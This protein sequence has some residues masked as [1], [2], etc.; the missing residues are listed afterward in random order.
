[1]S[2]L[3]LL[4]FLDVCKWIFL[5]ILFLVIDTCCVKGWEVAHWMF[6]RKED[7]FIIF[8]VFSFP[9]LLVWVCVFLFFVTIFFFF[10]CSFLACCLGL[11]F[12]F[13][14]YC[15]FLACCLGFHFFFVNIYLQQSTCNS[16]WYLD[17]LCLWFSIEKTL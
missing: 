8:I 11:H 10:Y 14:F 1:M 7:G 9:A 16:F 15:S 6:A 5:F 3:T 12:L 13:F 17:L 2:C 4:R